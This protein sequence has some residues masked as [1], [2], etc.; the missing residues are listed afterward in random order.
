M[1]PATPP[2][3]TAFI[4]AP[5]SSWCHVLAAWPAL[6][7]V[8]TARAAVLGRDPGEGLLHMLAAARPGDLLAAVA[9]SWAAHGYSSRFGNDAQLYPLGYLGPGLADRKSTRLNSSHF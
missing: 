3:T 8:L 2:T 5:L 6:R 7:L 9:D 1:P 4:C